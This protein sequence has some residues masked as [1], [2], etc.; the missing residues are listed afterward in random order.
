MARAHYWS[1]W[2]WIGLDEFALW[3][4]LRDVYWAREVRASLDAVVLFGTLL[5]I[6]IW[7]APLWKGLLREFPKR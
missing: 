2:G 5:V 6:G 4:N 3:L 1:G 7:G